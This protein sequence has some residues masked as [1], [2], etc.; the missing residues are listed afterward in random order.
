MSAQCAQQFC[1]RTRCEGD[2]GRFPSHD[3]KGSGQNAPQRSLFFL[4]PSTSPPPDSRGPTSDSRGPTKTKWGGGNG[5][6]AL[7][8][9]PGKQSHERER[10]QR[11]HHRPLAK[12]VL[13]RLRQSEVSNIFVVFVGS[14]HVQLP[15]TRTTHLSLSLQPTSFSSQ[16]TETPPPLPLERASSGNRKFSPSPFE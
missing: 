6:L 12:C 9:T 7:L 2:S 5:N 11:Q 15:A 13:H 14:R 10:W 16:P 8:T 4:L 1:M 3:A